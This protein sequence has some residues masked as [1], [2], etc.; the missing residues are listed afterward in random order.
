M[1]K[2]F[3]IADWKWLD[4]RR[5]Q[6]SK[7]FAGQVYKE[8]IKG[9]RPYLPYWTGKTEESIKSL[10]NYEHSSIRVYYMTTY[11]SEIYRGYYFGVR[12][13]PKKK[14]HP[15]ATTKWDEVYYRENPD[16]LNKLYTSYIEQNM[17]KWIRKGT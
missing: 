9:S 16:P 5:S 10:N 1:A 13:E 15:K 8:Y 12:R 11:A 3:L 6:S 2:K 7:V 17:E 4:V 14:Y